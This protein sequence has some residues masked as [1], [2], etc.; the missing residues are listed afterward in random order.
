MV[1]A[2]Q[3]GSVPVIPSVH[4]ALQAPLLFAPAGFVVGI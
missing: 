4:D 3:M 1:E 2:V